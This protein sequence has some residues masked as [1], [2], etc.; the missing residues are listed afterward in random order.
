MLYVV[1]PISLKKRNG[2]VLVYDTDDMTAEMH[3]IQ[4]VLGVMQV[5][6]EFANAEYSCESDKLYLRTYVRNGEFRVYYTSGGSFDVHR[7]TKNYYMSV[8]YDNY[9]MSDVFYKTIV[10]YH[11]A[12]SYHIFI[13]GGKDCFAFYENYGGVHFPKSWGLDSEGMYWLTPPVYVKG[14]LGFY[15]V[16]GSIGSQRLTY[17]WHDMATS[18]IVKHS[19]ELCSRIRKM[20]LLDSD[21]VNILGELR[22]L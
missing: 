8:F 3:K 19:R 5:G 10:T 15:I 22:L 18:P 12:S 1:S 7:A 13:A 11:N 4:D 17:R 20:A 14:R 2:S 9:R 21:E 16:G 6:M